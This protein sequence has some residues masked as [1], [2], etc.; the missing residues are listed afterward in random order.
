MTKIEYKPHCGKCGALIDEEVTYRDVV[1]EDKSIRDYSYLS[2]V[3][4]EPYRC[5]HCG[6]MFDRIEIR[7]PKNDGEIKI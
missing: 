1:I 4:I 6:E 3:A 7:I 5:S 2:G